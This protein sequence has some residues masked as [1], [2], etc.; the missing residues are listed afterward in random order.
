MKV[1]VLGLGYVGTVTAAGLAARGHDVVGVD[2]DRFKI[3]CIAA[4]RSPII[5]PGIDELVNEAVSAGR[6]SATDRIADALE[7][8]DV[9]L[10]CVGTPSSSNGST[11]LRFIERVTADLRQA[12]ESVE[13][14]ASGHHS[15]VVRSTVPPGTVGHLAETYFSD[16]PDGWRIGTAMCPEFLREG[17]SVTDFYDPPMVVV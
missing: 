11:D 13:P 8:A 17:C 2:V 4:G 14:P 10:I 5:E 16:V 3:G 1:A 12:M 9:S 6:L 15:V 7:G